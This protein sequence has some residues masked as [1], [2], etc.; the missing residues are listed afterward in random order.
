MH[1]IHALR[2]PTHCLTIT[3]T[4]LH[5]TRLRKRTGIISTIEHT[6]SR[7]DTP[8][9]NPTTVLQPA[10][11]RH[12]LDMNIPV[13]QRRPFSIIIS[14]A[15]AAPGPGILIQL[16]ALL[17]PLGLSAFT[18]TTSPL[19]ANST[20]A[21]YSSILALPNLLAPNGPTSLSNALAPLKRVSIGL[22]GSIAIIYSSL[23]SYALFASHPRQE[24]IAPIAIQSPD[25]GTAQ[26]LALL[27]IACPPT[28]TIYSLNSSANRLT[29]QSRQTVALAATCRHIQS[30]FPSSQITCSP[31][32]FHYGLPSFYRCTIT[33]TSCFN[34]KTIYHGTSAHEK[35]SAHI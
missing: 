25:T 11:I 31:P 21:L 8:L 32:T 9:I 19:F 23:T 33:T 4:H 10:R 1:I 20:H 17:Q 26:L 14:I 34:I 2:A 16:L 5:L 6:S 24:Y 35:N 22:L 13:Q 7:T 28:V 27:T 3:A 18:I 15:A 29:L 30:F 12:F